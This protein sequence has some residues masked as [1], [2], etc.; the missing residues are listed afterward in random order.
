MKKLVLAAALGA[1]VL[2]GAFLQ[3]LFLLKQENPF[4]VWD[5]VDDYDLEQAVIDWENE[6]YEEDL[7]DL[8]D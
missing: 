4:D 8:E 3:S 1:A 2:L 5:E 7:K 6:R